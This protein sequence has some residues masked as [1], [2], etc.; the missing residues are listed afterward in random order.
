MGGG[1]GCVGGVFG[2]LGW[3]GEVEL[4]VLRWV[5][6][7]CGVWRAH[8]PVEENIF[9]LEVSVV[10]VVLV[11]MVQRRDNVHEVAPRLVFWQPTA[12]GNPVEELAALPDTRT[13]VETSS[14]LRGWAPTPTLLR[15]WAPEAPL[16][17]PP[18]LRAHPPHSAPIPLTP[19]PSPLTLRLAQ[20]HDHVDP[21]VMHVNLGRRGT[22]GECG[23]QLHKFTATSRV[24]G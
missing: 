7:L 5:V 17:Q 15:P 22:H 19:R 16:A 2:V 13:T 21:F 8:L 6:G 9:R 11:A 3:G 4:C 12:F 20:L 24:M 23:G 18:S 1:L 10:H 14:R